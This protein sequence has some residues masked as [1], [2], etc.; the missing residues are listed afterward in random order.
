MKIAICTPHHSLVTSHYA[1][2]MVRMVMK[3]SECIFDFNGQP[4]KAELNLMMRSSS[5]LPLARSLLV[6][7]AVEWGANYMLWVDSDHWF[8]DNA[9]LRLLSWNIPVV[10]ANY[11]RRERPTYPTAHGLDEELIW[12]TEEQAKSDAIEPVGTLGLGFCLVDMSVIHAIR[13]L[14]PDGTPRRMFAIGMTADWSGYIG[15]DAY[16]FQKIRDAGFAVHLDHG[17]S[18]QIGHAAESL[19]FNSDALADKAEYSRGTAR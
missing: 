5:L 6:E 16:F 7:D 17:L 3:T 9:L 4:T 14:N 8:P 18:W 10:G 13:K 15:E 2:C 19:L 1:S 12:T 11:P